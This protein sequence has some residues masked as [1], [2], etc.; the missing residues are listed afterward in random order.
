MARSTSASRGQAEQDMPHENKALSFPADWEPV[1]RDLSGSMELQVAGLDVTVDLSEDEL[2]RVHAPFIAYLN[3]HPLPHDACRGVA[4]LAGIPGSGKSTF[5]ASV[6][7]VADRLLGEGV[8]VAVG[9]DGW[10][11]PNA[12]LDQRTT[13]D[14]TSELIPLRQRKGGPESFDTPGLAEAVTRLRTEPDLVRLPVYDRRLHDPVA[15]GNAILPIT[16]IVLLE[17]NFLLSN[18]PA[19]QPVS[20]QL[21]PKCLV[22]C[23]PDAA[24]K[25]VI[26]RH[27][28][29]GCTPDKARAQFESNDR[30]NTEAVQATVAEADLWIVPTGEQAGVYRQPPS[31]SA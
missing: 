31:N 29:G 19:W 4:G 9:M 21:G 2:Y 25:R 24:R 10:H 1:L 6:E 20:S 8:L 16:R 28:R 11:F 30:L 13:R 7:R 12:I 14:D 5:A 18:D 22:T 27:V 17:G 26:D 3:E 23:D 15:D